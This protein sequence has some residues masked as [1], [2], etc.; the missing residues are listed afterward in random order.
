MVPREFGNERITTAPAVSRAYICMFV[1]FRVRGMIVV[2][3]DHRYKWTEQ[4]K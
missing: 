1:L 2:L 3:S 4:I